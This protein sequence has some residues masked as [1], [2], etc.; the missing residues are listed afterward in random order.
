M[1]SMF[2]ATHIFYVPGKPGIIDVA[3]PNG[4][5]WCGNL[6]LEQ[7]QAEY[8]G[9]V[10]ASWEEAAPGIDAAH[11]KAFAHAPTRTDRETF[12]SMLNELPPDDW[13]REAGSESFKM[14]EHTSGN[15]TT[16]F[17]RIGDDFWTLSD[18]AGM[19][20]AEIIRRCRE[21]DAA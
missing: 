5:S 18:D 13:H 4:L 17:A 9:C 8:P 3:R 10:R 6:T 2:D 7:L 15:I 16:I 11:R 21:A 20:H 19:P 1:P 12:D 14:C